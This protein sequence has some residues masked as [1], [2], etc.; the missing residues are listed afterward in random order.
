MG[1]RRQWRQRV[2]GG[3]TVPELRPSLQKLVAKVVVERAI[4]FA[5]VIVI[6]SFL[7]SLVFRRC[8]LGSTSVFSPGYFEGVVGGWGRH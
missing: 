5:S 1:G 4:T 6:F 7:V 3:K 8:S 2:V